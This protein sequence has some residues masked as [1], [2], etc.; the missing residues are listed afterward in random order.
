[1]TVGLDQ[2]WISSI[3]FIK[4]NMHLTPELI[5]TKQDFTV[6]EP[7]QRNGWFQYTGN[8][9]LFPTECL[10]MYNAVYK[11]SVRDLRI[12][13]Y[14]SDQPHQNFPRLSHIFSSINCL[15]VLERLLSLATHFL[16]PCLWG[17][18]WVMGEWSPIFPLVVHRRR[19]V[20][21]I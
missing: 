5:K 17:W 4:N 12:F 21:M 2:K 13:Q 19:F 10:L 8:I 14:S 6:A 20:S 1:M 9:E 7:S 18:G 11:Q 3:L 16:N 15:E